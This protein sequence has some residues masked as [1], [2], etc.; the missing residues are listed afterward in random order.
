MPTFAASP[1]YLARAE[2]RII[3]AEVAIDREAA[4]LVK[5]LF[6]ER[7]Q[8]PIALTAWALVES[9]PRP[10]PFGANVPIN[11]ATSKTCPSPAP[12]WQLRR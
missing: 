4:V 2:Q 11:N 5:G 12:Q 10:R 8:G 1:D 7:P 9:S 6:V 3:D